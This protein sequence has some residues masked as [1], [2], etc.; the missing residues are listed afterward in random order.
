MKFRPRHLACLILLLSSMSGAEASALRADYTLGGHYIGM[1]LAQDHAGVCTEAALVRHQRDL[2]HLDLPVALVARHRPAF[3]LRPP[4][5]HSLQL[6][7][8]TSFGA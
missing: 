1:L 3:A 5:A 6:Q 4:A 7:A 2:S 8:V